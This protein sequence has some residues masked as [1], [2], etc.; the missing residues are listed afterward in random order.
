[1]AET[2]L[3]EVEIPVERIQIVNIPDGMKVELVEDRESLELEVGGFVSDKEEF[4]VDDIRVKVDILVYMNKE[5]V[6]ELP[7]GTYTL[8]VILELPEVV[9]T[10]DSVQAKIKVTKK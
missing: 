3:E 2:F 5:N 9:W 6:I 1:M 7:A 4:S 10:Q 8:D